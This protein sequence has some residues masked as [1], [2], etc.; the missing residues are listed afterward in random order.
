MTTVNIIF[1]KPAWVMMK[2]IRM[3]TYVLKVIVHDPKI[4]NYLL[5]HTQAVLLEYL[6]IKYNIAV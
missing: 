5:M 3:R 4:Q 2:C 6:V 1:K